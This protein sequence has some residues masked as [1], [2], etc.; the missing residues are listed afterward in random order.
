MKTK[1]DLAQWLSDSTLSALDIDIKWRDFNK[2]IDDFLL[3]NH[4][5]LVLKEK[6]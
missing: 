1:A 6:E 2:F 3:D 4:L 5:E